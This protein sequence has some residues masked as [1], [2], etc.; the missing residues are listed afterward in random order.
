MCLIAYL[1]NGHGTIWGNGGKFELAFYY[2]YPKWGRKVERLG[3]RVSVRG[4]IGPDPP[5]VLEQ[6][7]FPLGSG[8]ANRELVLELDERPKFG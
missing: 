4:K 1:L 3:S 7:Y 5:Y 8:K 6:F 2:A